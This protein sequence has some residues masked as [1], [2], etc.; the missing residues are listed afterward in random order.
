MSLEPE[1]QRLNS[2]TLAK[3]P[4]AITVPKYDRSAVSAGIVHLGTGNFHRAHQ[5][6]YCEKLLNQGATT[7]GIT[8]VSLRS[9]TIRD[10]LAPQDFL[11]TQATLGE[12]TSY[13]VIGAIQGLLV[14]PEDPQAVVA[15]IAHSRT[16]LV[17]T[18]I[19][20]KGYCLN[21]GKIDFQHSGFSQDLSSLTTP[22][23]AY[24]YLAAALI[25]RCTEQGESLT[26]LC[27]DNIQNGGAHLQAGVEALLHKHSPQTLAWVTKSVAFASSMVDRVTPATDEKLQRDVAAG[28]GM[29]DAAPVA[30]EPFTQWIIEDRFAGQRPPFERVGG[31]FV[32]DIAPFE[33]VKLRFLNASHSILAALGY[34]AGDQFVHE[35]LRRPSLAQFTEQALQHDVLPV[36]AIPES[37]NGEV[38]ID[39]VLARFRNHNLPYAVLQ[40]G[41]DSSQKIQQRWLPTI[42]DALTQN[43]DPLYLAFALAAWARFI[44][45]ALQNN[46]LSD[47]LET[48]FAKHN[49]AGDTSDVERF[50]ALAGATKF[51]FF[52]QQSFMA[53]VQEYYQAIGA[54]GVEQS[55][56]TFLETTK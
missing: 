36:T 17:T 37:I 49:S 27:C 11:Y 50:L 46:D 2:L 52:T 40:V 24:G 32:A 16:Q 8:G 28:L 48:E 51:A 14:A 43:R 38:Y 33:H 47:P 22:Q 5:A 39:E 6:V 45:Q 21:D 3:V 42:D 4:A 15:A 31:Q 34:L 7:W 35:A 54:S 13:R 29:I 53:Q 44:R 12:S 23:T 41:T 18:T 9:A 10:K 20:E 55:L 26:I 25:K 56:T 30:A 1:L 19:T